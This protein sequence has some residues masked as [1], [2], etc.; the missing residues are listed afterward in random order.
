MILKK[1]ANRKGAKAPRKIMVFSFSGNRLPGEYSSGCGLAFS[2]RLRA[3]AV[4]ESQ[5]PR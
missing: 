2:L 5:F 1:Q 3:F 4:K